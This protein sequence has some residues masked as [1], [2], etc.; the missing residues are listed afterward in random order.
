LKKFDLVV[1]GGGVAGAE[2]A[3][4]AA[5][6]AKMEG[7]S[8]TVALISCEETVYSKSAL[9]SVISS[10][11]CS[12]EE[13]IVYPLFMLKDLGIIVYPLYEVLSVN[14]EE[15]TVSARSLQTNQRM[16]I[17]FERLILCTGSVPEIL[18]IKGANLSGVY[19]VKWFK[20][21]EE[22]SR[23]A[24]A[25]MKAL[26]VGP[27]LV[28]LAAANAL[29]KRGLKLTVLA[30]TRILS[31]V[32]EPFLGEIMHKK[33]ESMGVTILVGSKLQEIGGKGRVE[34]IIIDGKKF[35]F[36]FVIMATGVKPNTAILNGTSVELSDYGA[37][38]T[39]TK[40]QTNLE[41][42]YS[43][44]DCAEKLDFITGKTV[45]RPLG[46]VATRTAKIAGF[47]VLGEE[48]TFEGSIRHQYD[49]L[50]NTHITSMGLTSREA[51]PL[52][53]KTESLRVELPLDIAAYDRELLKRPY[54]VKMC[55][56]IEKGSDR[57]VGWESIGS[58]KL[59]NTYNVYINEL[60]KNRGKVEELQSLGFKLP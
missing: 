25:G 23:K 29:L 17:A 31:Y 3:Y 19:T 4:A 21:A 55:A 22:L 2:A 10:E 54:G 20:D 13:I 16:E 15:R 45:H 35:D 24:K 47:N 26:V 51:E 52:G 56:V 36:D 48:I 11:V 30:R 28:G 7:K 44:G 18:R 53:V 5:Y 38:K 41:H 33:L 37:V 6:K 57:I 46:S 8:F 50:F 43:V 60:I 58:V 42:V 14:F 49:Y 1:V 12:L 27:G 9:P 59:T 40:M 34:Y 39:D 32:L